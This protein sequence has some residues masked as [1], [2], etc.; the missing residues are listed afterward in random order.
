[1]D[2]TKILDK[3]VDKQ[4]NLDKIFKLSDSD[5]TIVLDLFKELFDSFYG[6]KGM[7][8]AGGMKI[9]YI[10]SLVIYNTL[11]DNDYLITKREASLDK[12]LS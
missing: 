4:L 12:V 1:M 8:F 11:I 10:R 5:K 6:E 2:S 9:D 3:I 7:V